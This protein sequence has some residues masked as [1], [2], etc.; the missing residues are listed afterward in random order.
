MILTGL[1]AVAVRLIVYNPWLLICTCNIIMLLQVPCVIVL[2]CAAMIL[3]YIRDIEGITGGPEAYEN[4]HLYKMA[5]WLLVIMSI[6]G[7]SF[8][9]VLRKVR[10]RHFNSYMNND[11]TFGYVVGLSIAS[12]VHACMYSGTPLIRTPLIRAPQLSGRQT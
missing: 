3:L 11:V 6:I 12:Y 9:Y 2:I 8:H 7:L 10:D 4:S 1:L 5:A